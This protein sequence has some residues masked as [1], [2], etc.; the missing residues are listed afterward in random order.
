MNVDTLAWLVR[1]LATT[2][3]ETFEYKDDSGHIL[4]RFGSPS[5]SSATA[6]PDV[7]P[8]RA[9]ETAIV[10]PRVGHFFSTHPLEARP[11]VV[12]GDRVAKGQHVAFVLVED[13]VS[14]IFA[15]HDGVIGA[16]CVEEGTLVG[17][18]TMLFPLE[19][20]EGRQ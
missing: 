4:L 18:G 12:A 10:A 20:D 7:P 11:L 1:R 19:A 15:S 9:Q 14:P 8:S 6:L 17:Y 3:I 13:R 5:S 2:S 16:A